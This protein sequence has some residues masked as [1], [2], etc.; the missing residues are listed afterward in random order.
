MTKIVDQKLKNFC[1]FLKRT[2]SNIGRET[3][4]NVI[5]NQPSVVPCA[6]QIACTF[7]NISSK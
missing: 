7:Q 1:K 6:K 3:T 4:Q 2:W 5:K